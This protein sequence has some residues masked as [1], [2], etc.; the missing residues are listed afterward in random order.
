MLEEHDECVADPAELLA[1]AGDR[2]RIFFDGRVG[3]LPY[4]DREVVSPWEGLGDGTLE[5]QIEIRYSDLLKI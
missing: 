2:Q 5:R 4:I 1:V 3:R